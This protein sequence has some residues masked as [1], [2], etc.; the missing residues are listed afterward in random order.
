MKKYFKNNLS[1]MWHEK[2]FYSFE[3]SVTFYSSIARRLIRTHSH[4]TAYG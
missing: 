4:V 2:Y 3:K 1:Y